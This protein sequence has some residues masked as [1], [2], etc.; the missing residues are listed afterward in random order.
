MDRDQLGA[1]GAPPPAQERAPQSAA[2]PERAQMARA[3][4]QEP[5]ADNLTHGC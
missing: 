5:T 3:T 4:P 1:Q 2:S